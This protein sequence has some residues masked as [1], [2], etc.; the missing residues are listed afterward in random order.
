MVTQK[1]LRICESI[2]KSDF[3]SKRPVF[4]HTCAVCSELPSNTGT[5]EWPNVGREGYWHWQLDSVWA[6]INI[7]ESNSGKYQWCGSER[8]SLGSE[9]NHTLSRRETFWSFLISILPFSFLFLLMFFPWQ[10][11]FPVGH[12]GWWYPLSGPW[13]RKRSGQVETKI[14]IRMRQAKY[15]RIPTGSKSSSRVSGKYFAESLHKGEVYYQPHGVS[16]C[17]KKIFRRPHS[18]PVKEKI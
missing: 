14:R 3:C 15:H 6:E 12:T 18:T 5:M 4:P 9:S 16:P 13:F 17:P 7:I 11:F 1:Q 10:P 8:I 2:H